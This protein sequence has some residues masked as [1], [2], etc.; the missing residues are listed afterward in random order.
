MQVRFLL[1]DIRC[2]GDSMKKMKTLFNRHFVKHKIVGIDTVPAEGCEWVLK[3]E[4]VATRKL[5]GTCCL[6]KDGVLFARF[7]W[8]RGRKLPQGAIPCQ[9]QPDSITGSFPHWIPVTDDNRFKWHRLAFEKLEDK[10]DGT[11]ELIGK[12]I[13]GNPDGVE[14][15]DIFVRHGSIVLDDVPRTFEGIKEFLR[16]HEIE[17]IVFHRENGEM[18]KIKRTDFGFDWNNNLKRY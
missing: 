9:E 5:D 13:N 16:T 15:G 11:F 2:L 8:K 4:G 3:G 7:D 10:S 18:C 6:I 12:H 17:G 14:D 1:L